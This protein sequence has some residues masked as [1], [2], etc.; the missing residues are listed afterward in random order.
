MSI[1]K[2]KRLMIVSACALVMLSGC[3]TKDSDDKKSSKDDTKTEQSSKTDDKEDDSKKEDKDT[4]ETQKPS[5]TQEPSETQKL[6]ETQKP[7]DPDDPEKE[8]DEK[9]VKKS[10]M[11]EDFYIQKTCM[12]T[13][14]DEPDTYRTLA[15]ASFDKIVFSDETKAAFPKLT[16]AVTAKLDEM[17]ATFE[18]EQKDLEQSAKETFKEN[19][20]IGEFFLEYNMTITR[21]DNKSLS[22]VI[23]NLAYTGGAHPYGYFKSL[24]FDPATGDELKLSDIIKDKEAFK[25]AAAECAVRSYN[26]EDDTEN[27]KGSLENYLGGDNLVWTLDPEGLTIYIAAGEVG[28]YAAGSFVITVPF[29]Q[30]TD[31]FNDAA[32]LKMDNYAISGN[33]YTADVDGDGKYE[34]I[35]ATSIQDKVDEYHYTPRIIVDGKN[36]DFTEDAYSFNSYLIC[37]AGKYYLIEIGL[38]D[39]DYHTLSVYSID[40]DG[41]KL[42]KDRMDGLSG[43]ISAYY[44]GYDEDEPMYKFS[45]SA[46][47]FYNPDR[48]YVTVRDDI[49]STVN[50]TAQVSFNEDGSL[51]VKDDLYTV[52]YKIRLKLKKDLK[53]EKLKEYGVSDKETTLKA[54]TELE[55]AAS[56]NQNEVILKTDDGQLVK[57]KV[58]V[59]EWPRTIDGVDIEEIFDG[60]IFA[61]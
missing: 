13:N 18:K 43:R 34:K 61:G 5:E 48:F 7:E 37:K 30:Y 38:E 50:S 21:A 20:N 42:V 12:Y 53:V 10:L 25:K 31:A 55:I 45:E 35:E 47:T 11:D 17:Y 51:T 9:D 14:S 46:P 24:N 15:Q 23:S 32:S 57:V 19:V 60:T 26:F 44:D 4:E 59:E 49:I 54:G 3:G 22:F 41:V 29:T 27:V 33:V 56:N 39:N 40:K 8:N 16:A 28:S 52:F 2:L 58:E 6:S 1:Y 36:Y